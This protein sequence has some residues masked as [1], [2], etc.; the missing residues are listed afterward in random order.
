[1]LIFAWRK[2]QNLMAVVFSLSNSLYLSR[3]MARGI[4]TSSAG[5]LKLEYNIDYNLRSLNKSNFI[6][7]ELLSAE[8]CTPRRLL[9]AWALNPAL[10][11]FLA[12]SQYDLYAGLLRRIFWSNRDPCLISFSA[13]AEDLDRCPF[14]GRCLFC[15]FLGL[16]HWSC[17]STTSF[18]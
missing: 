18:L 6:R 15:Y 1:M 9:S 3:Y 8:T 11:A 17:F 2:I 5:A 13:S 4:Y 7:T 14:L 12:F 16:F 10:V